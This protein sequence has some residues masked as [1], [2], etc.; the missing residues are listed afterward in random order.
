MINYMPTQLTKLPRRA[1]IT[2][3]LNEERRLLL[4]RIAVVLAVLGLSY[5][6]GQRPRY[7]L[8][9]YGAVV[10]A[11]GALFLMRYIQ[12]GVV[13]LVVA[14]LVVPIDLST[15]T[16]SRVNAPMLVILGLS[17][18]WLL[19]MIVKQGQ[20][21]FMRS[22]SLLSLVAMIIVAIVAF[23]G[24]QLPWFREAQSASTAAQ[25]GGLFL[26]IASALVYA[27]VGHHLRDIKWLQL[28][29]WAFII[30]GTLYTAGRMFPQ[31]GQLQGFFP[32][33]VGAG[34]LFWV[35][36]G[37]MTFSQLVI[38]RKLHWGWRILLALSLGITL[39]VAFIQSYDWK[40]GWVPTF[41]AIGVTL[42]LWMPRFII[43]G[44]LIGLTPILNFG[45]SALESDLYSWETRVDAWLIMVE[46]I[47][48]NPLFGLGP[49]NYYFYTPL[50][51]I[52]GYYVSF[53]SHNQY[54]DVVAQI[55]LLG[56]LCLVWFF[57][58]IGK[59]SWSLLKRAPEGFAQAFVF[60]AIGGLVGTIVAGMLGDWIIPFVYNV[61]FDG[62]R[63]SIF[64]WLFLGA[65][66]AMDQMYPEAEA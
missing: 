39:Y 44:V 34:S 2:L 22:R 3:W 53:N 15:G 16:D 42:G 9:I 50:F 45:G 4:L 14:A 64:A 37:A 19:D 33:A 1:Y 11:I 35:W 27:W 28:A 46:I 49:S 29:V 8:P 36:L 55:G 30:L 48:V 60:G 18:L 31:L 20:V 5:Y 7:A 25:A 56:L 47:K 26:F 57:W 12:I 61:G 63:A 21:Q 66:L 58:E 13:G 65:L 10:A 51:S 24:G 54:F 6:L 62:F 23:I 52:R 32:W 17:G 41:I 59:I 40:S 38:N 43:A